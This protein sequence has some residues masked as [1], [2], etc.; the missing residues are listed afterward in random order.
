MLRSAFHAAQY[1][2]PIMGIG[3]KCADPFVRIIA[4]YGGKVTKNTG[5]ASEA[6]LPGHNV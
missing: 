6:A 1:L 2:L 5:N 4:G 3:V